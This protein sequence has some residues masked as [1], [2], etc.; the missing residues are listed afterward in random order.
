MGKYGKIENML[1][2]I[3]QRASNDDGS[4]GAGLHLKEE[5]PDP[6]SVSEAM[7]QIE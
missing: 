7:I 3:N 4:P 5:G 1:Q 6:V 2:T